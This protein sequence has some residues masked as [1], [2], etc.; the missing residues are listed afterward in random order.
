MKGKCS[1]YRVTFVFSSPL[2][3]VALLL[4]FINTIYG[5]TDDD[6]PWATKGAVKPTKGHNYGSKMF[7]EDD[8]DILSARNSIATKGTKLWKKLQR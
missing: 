5:Y 4:I 6:D 1:D 7:I 3:T 8:P 2:F